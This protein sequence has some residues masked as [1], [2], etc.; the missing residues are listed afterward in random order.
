MTLDHFGKPIY[1]YLYQCFGFFSAAEGFFFLS[2]FVG[3]LAATSKSTKDPKQS[4][5]VKR[6]IR[7]WL[8]H[9]T[10][11]LLICGLA[12]FF[13]PRIQWFFKP[14]FNHGIEAFPL[15]ATLVYT[16]EYLDVL[17]LYVLLLLIGSLMFPLF[18]KAKSK[19]KILLLWLPSMVVWGIAQ[20]GILH[21]TVTSIFPQWVH[22]GNFHPFSWQFV[23]FTGAAV[24]AWWN[25]SNDQDKALVKRLTPWLLLPFTFCLLWS[26]NF[27]PV[28][29]PTEWLTSKQF[30][31][32]LRIANFFVFVML[33]SYIVRRWPAALDFKFTNI[34]GRHSLDVYTFQT[35][36]VFLWFAFPKEIRNQGP[37]N[38]IAP[39]TACTLLLAL[40]KIREPKN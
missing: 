27:I 34:I 18:V 17:P 22:H 10:S 37:W 12:Y 26:H 39:L 4:W 21:S 5:M 13:L 1:S 14:F 30:L 6:S 24:A 9:F 15:A 36:L 38:V 3:I 31:G 19:T 29:Q 20:T 40:A 16:P 2:G 8:Y 11:L 25:R 28:G 32:S 33:T 35:I 23:Y 7:I